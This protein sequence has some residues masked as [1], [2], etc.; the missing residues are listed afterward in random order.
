M[1]KPWRWA[2]A[3]V[4]AAAFAMPLVSFFDKGSCQKIPISS[5]T[6]GLNFRRERDLPLDADSFVWRCGD[7]ATTPLLVPSPTRGGSWTTAF[8]MNP[9]LRPNQDDH[10]IEK[11]HFRPIYARRSNEIIMDLRSH[12]RKKQRH[13]RSGV[14]L[15]GL[16]AISLYNLEI[17]RRKL[18]PHS[19]GTVARR[20]SEVR[21][22]VHFTGSAVIFGWFGASPRELELAQRVYRKNGFHDVTVVASPIKE[23]TSPRG[24]HQVV[25][26]HRELGD[27][28]PL[29]RRVD[30]VH[31]LSGGFLN[32]YLLRAAGVPLECGDALLLDSTPI[33]PKPKAFATF[34]RQFLRDS[35]KTR[36]V[37]LVPKALHER[38]VRWRW[39]VSAASVFV[40]QWLRRLG[41]V[42]RQA[43]TRGPADSKLKTWTQFCMA[44]AI[45]CSYGD[46]VDHMTSTIFGSS[47]KVSSP[48]R[49]VFLH[50]PED[51]Y[52]DSDDVE[53][54]MSRA[55]EMAPAV[56]R[57]AVK[58]GHI[59]TLFRKPKQVF[60][61]LYASEETSKPRSRKE[62]SN[63]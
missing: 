20:E 16:L 56:E 62:L 19:R 25:K 61:A 45:K 40:T 14:L 33:L 58:T 26:K 63:V 37:K 12:T 7:D 50:N 55:R 6:S 44:S 1:A 34:T 5:V 29:A 21:G 15:A 52:L 49:V 17:S 57:C 43:K 35:G 10:G 30:V 28:H 23:M 59:E 9:H 4:L 8:L 18:Y 54:T 13:E 27:K 41:G 22:L 2:K 39:Q 36:A 38:L 31:C 46:V 53:S 24:W 48:K 11:R 60:N 3:A 51:P 32:F 47:T 42:F